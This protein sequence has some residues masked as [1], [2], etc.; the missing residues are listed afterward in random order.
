MPPPRSRAPGKSA[1]SSAKGKTLRILLVGRAGKLAEAVARGLSGQEGI[2]LSRPLLD[3]LDSPD[4]LAKPVRDFDAFIGL[5]ASREDLDPL[6]RLLAR[7]GSSVAPLAVLGRK[8][9]WLRR[10][11]REEGFLLTVPV[12]GLSPA[13]TRRRL[14]QLTVNLRSGLLDLLRLQQHTL[15]ALHRIRSPLTGIQGN[16]EMAAW[17][18]ASPE[19][20]ANQLQEIIRGVAEIEVILRDMEAQIRGE[21][22]R[23]R[24]A[25]GL[26]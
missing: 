14:A 2:K 23:P 3:S 11:V 12:H 24:A 26:L 20:R 13:G 10:Q 19:Q 1:S 8:D 6:G 25:G 21:A 15:N 7:V 9:V 4:A 22:A 18:S 17:K 16:A 5:V